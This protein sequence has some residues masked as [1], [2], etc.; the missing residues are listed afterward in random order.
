M[1]EISFKI[2]REKVGEMQ[3][4]FFKMK[5]VEKIETLPVGR[6]KN[7][8]LWTTVHYRGFREMMAIAKLVDELKLKT[9]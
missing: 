2:D 8:V 7:A 1:N 6:G 4:A 5:T 3:A 9:K